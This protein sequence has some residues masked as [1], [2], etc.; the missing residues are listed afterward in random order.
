MPN[1]CNGCLNLNFLHILNAIICFINRSLITSTVGCISKN[2]LPGVT[3][4][5]K[6]LCL[7]G[8][9][10]TGISGLLWKK[11]I[12]E[13]LQVTINDPHETSFS[14]ITENAKNNDVKV[15]ITKEDPCI[16]LHQ[17]PFHFM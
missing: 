14:V 5:R 12:G 15:E 2:G 13:N 4:N 9:G 11:Y 3:D 17:R 10:G 6:I 1:Y 8:I 7:D 16:I